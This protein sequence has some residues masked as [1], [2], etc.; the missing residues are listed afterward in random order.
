MFILSK[1][2]KIFVNFNNVASIYIQEAY[3][4]DRQW[5]I[6]AMYAA[7]SEDVLYDTLDIYYTEQ[8]C[9]N[10]FQRL[11]DCI[12]NS[13]EHEIINIQDLWC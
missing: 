9:K 11:C 5:E 12:A 1:N 13:R 6:R 8:E 2:E 3:R 7:I 4:P 10:A